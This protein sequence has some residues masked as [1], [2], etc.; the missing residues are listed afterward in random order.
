MTPDTVDALIRLAWIPFVTAFIGWITNWLA[1]Q[2]LF[3]P[4]QPLNFLGIKFQGLI[5]R[6]Q[7][8][9]ADRVAEVVEQEFLSQHLIREQLAHLDVHSYVD[10]FVRRLVRERLGVKL[11]GIPLVGSMINDSTL[12]MLE[13]MA[14]DSIH[15]EIEPL[16]N[17]IATD[18]ET[19]LQVRDIVR[20]RILT[21][22]MEKL[23][24]LVRRI[25]SNEF[26]LIEILGGVLGFIVGLV[27]VGILL[28]IG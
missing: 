28:L 14:L 13:K 18:L 6:R 24:E 12:S 10:E 5:P 25:A 23:E 3:R 7:V 20:D 19:R 27:Q 16:R 4:R 22:E 9:I 1:I 8:E 26:K 2:M 17:R 11:R 21:F 15:E